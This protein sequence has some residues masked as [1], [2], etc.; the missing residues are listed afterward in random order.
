MGRRGDGLAFDWVMVVLSAWLVGGAFLDGWAHNHGKVDTSLLTP[1]H[2]I[3]YTAFLALAGW[4]GG[5]LAH[6]CAK[7]YPFQ[8]ALPP[9]YALSCVGLL[10]FAAG[11]IGDLIWHY[12]F[13]VEQSVEALYSPTHLMLAVGSA[14]IVSG[15]FRAAWRRVDRTSTL[16]WYQLWPMLLSLTLMF[17]AFSFSAQVIHP[18][19]PLRRAM[20]LPSTDGMLFYL[21]ILTIASVLVQVLLRM[22]LILLA[23][24]R[25]RLPPGSLTLVF[26]LNS[27][28]M[29]TLDPRDAY[30]L[31][32]PVMLAGMMADGLLY[33]LRPA[34]ERS[35]RF[36]LFAFTVPVVFYLLY[37]S[38]L[39]L[40]YGYWWSV[41]LWTGTIVLGGLAG[42][43]LS[44]LIVPPQEPQAQ[45]AR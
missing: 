34:A 1:W 30:G 39:W 7:G 42:W 32:V 38:A 11:A 33:L 22:G 12:L 45:H 14:L 29:C 18:L 8:H 36:R 4:L 24:R 25:W 9:G 16:G 21:Q 15:P 23:L 44:Y 40:M 20:S 6:N 27:L 2:T 17:A 5:V 43:L 26:T 3:F 31:I 37:F 28:A 13:G 35:W 10:V 19:V 41:H